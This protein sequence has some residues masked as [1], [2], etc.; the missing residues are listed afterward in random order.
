DN[1]Y[2]TWKSLIEEAIAKM[3]AQITED[4]FNELVE[5][6]SQIKSMQE[7]QKSLQTAI[8]N[9]DYDSWA[10]LMTAQIT[11]DNFNELVEKH[12]KINESMKELKPFF[13]NSSKDLSK[14]PE[15]SETEIALREAIAN[16]N[17]DSWKTVMES[18][19]TEDNFNTLV[20]NY[21]QMKEQKSS[22]RN[23]E[24]LDSISDKKRQSPLEKQENRHS[25]LGFF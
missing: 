7:E 14:A 16:N 25:G 24:S 19:I 15:L 20:E 11:E 17:Y 10:S 6:N 5:Q 2:S 8:K 12:Q 1:D 3:Q 9:N 4:N 18:Q 13:E 23:F 22:D 21:S